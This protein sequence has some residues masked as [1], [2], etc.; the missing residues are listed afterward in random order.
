MGLHI[1]ISFL[2][3]IAGLHTLYMASAFFGIP[4][5]DLDHVL[6]IQNCW[7]KQWQCNGQGTLSL[8]YVVTLVLSAIS[9][10][11]RIKHFGYYCGIHFTS[12]RPDISFVRCG[13]IEK[14]DKAQVGRLRVRFPMRSLDFPTD[15]ILPATLWPWGRLSLWQK[16]VPGIF[17]GVKG[18]RPMRKADNLTAICE[19]IV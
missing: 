1:T 16:W 11:V 19:S 2:L 7:T 4:P 15:L 8:V 6:W 12:C 13:I 17:L 9:K 3:L 14:F 18:G 10:H 5:H